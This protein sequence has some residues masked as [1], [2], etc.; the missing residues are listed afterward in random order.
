MSFNYNEKLP[1]PNNFINEIHKP[2]KWLNNYVIIST[3][4]SAFYDNALDYYNEHYRIFP[5]TR[6]VGCPVRK[7]TTTNFFIV[8]DKSWWN[9]VKT[10]YNGD[11][12]RYYQALL[13]KS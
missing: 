4:V 5:H 1:N 7:N 6:V 2:E 10:M 13:T 9:F 11:L 3:V 8:M 12:N